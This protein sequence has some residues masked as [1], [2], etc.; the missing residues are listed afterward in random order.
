MA[1]VRKAGQP[2]NSSGGAFLGSGLG[3]L[4]GG[5]IGGWPGAAVVSQIGK[6]LGS[7]IDGGP[8]QHPKSRKGPTKAHST[9]K[10]NHLG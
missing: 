3:A 9:R 10:K 6:Q 7:T 4:L 2:P 8:G 1:S 5:A